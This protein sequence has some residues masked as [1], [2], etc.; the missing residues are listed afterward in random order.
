MTDQPLMREQVEELGSVHP[1]EKPCAIIA[2]QSVGAYTAL[3][4]LVNHDAAQRAEIEQLK[5]QVLTMKET[6]S[7]G[8]TDALRAER[9]D[10]RAKVWEE[11][12]QRA[13]KY[14]R[15]DERP[16][17]ASGRLT[18]II[19]RDECREQAAIARL[20]QESHDRS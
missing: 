7:R 12:A 10:E 9:Q 19:I 1:I 11:A 13:D 6:Q 8:L 5:A 15:D 4:L 17:A 3:S 14:W 2:G 18:A 16:E 20:E